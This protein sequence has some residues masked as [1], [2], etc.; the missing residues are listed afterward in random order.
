MVFETKLY[1][2]IRYTVL[3]LAVGFVIIPIVPVVFMAFKTGMEYQGTSVFTPPSNWL[4]MYNFAYAIRVGKLIGSLFT[5]LLVMLVSLF[6]SVNFGCMVGYVF[7]RF[8]FHGKKV[9]MLLYML[10]MFIPVVTT[11]VVGFRII[12]ALGLVNHIGS[13]MLLYSGVGIVDI[14][15][16]MNIL[17]TIPRS[18]DEAGLLD[19]AGYF[20]IYFSLIFPLLKPAIVTLAVIKGIGI[21]NDFYIPNLYL[22][23][24]SQ[25]LTVALYRFF[26]GLSTPFEVVSA[27]VLMATIPMIVLFLF[28]QRYI[29]NG[30]A[31][32]V[33]S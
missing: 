16:V 7:Q 4:N 9:T 19:G 14:Y 20:R 31:G 23:R 33:K 24:G 29:Y 6:F 32:A 11:Q 3:A 12:Y 27:A 2:V 5:T 8:E 10:T 26:N 21:Y 17:S 30:L 13:L 15:I 28:A 25:T 1:K 18:I 22:I